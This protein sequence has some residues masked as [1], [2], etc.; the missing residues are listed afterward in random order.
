MKSFFLVLANSLR[1]TFWKIIGAKTVGVR[2]IAVNNYDEVLLV[3]HTYKPGWHLPG[4]G[5]KR[6]ETLFE[7][8]IRELYE[9][10]GTKITNIKFLGIYNDFSE[11]RNDHIVLFT[12]SVI[13]TVTVNSFEIEDLK[14]FSRDEFPK[15]LDMHCKNKIYQFLDCEPSAHIGKW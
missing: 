11:G 12:G 15:D 5:I 7:A 4:G 6:N 9:E 3:K 2:I 1:N 14:F 8:A 10:T 13:T